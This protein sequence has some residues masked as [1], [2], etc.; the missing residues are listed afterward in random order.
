MLLSKLKEFIFLLSMHTTA[1]AIQTNYWESNKVQALLP[2]WDENNF[3]GNFLWHLHIYTTLQHIFPRLYSQKSK[4]KGTV[5]KNS[6]PETRIEQTQLQVLELDIPQPTKHKLGDLTEIK[7]KT[8]VD[9]QSFIPG[10]PRAPR[11]PWPG[12]KPHP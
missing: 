11:P 5:A 7:H 6:K 1:M 9:N 8:H 3:S 4:T 2:V 12:M 10:Q